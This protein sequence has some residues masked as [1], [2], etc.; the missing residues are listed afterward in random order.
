M[1]ANWIVILINIRAQRVLGPAQARRRTG[2]E[3]FAQEDFRSVRV[4]PVRCSW[5]PGAYPPRR[6]DAV[7]NRGQVQPT[8]INGIQDAVAPAFALLAGMQL[9]LFTPIAEDELTAEELAVRLDVNANRLSRL[10]YALAATGLVTEREGS[11]RDSPE[12]A[13]FLVRGRTRYMGGSHELLA[14]IWS[15][16]LRTAE[17]TRT[18]KPAAQH[19]WTQADTE[20]DAAALRGLAPLAL[21]FG[22]A[23]GERLDLSKVGSVVDIGGGSGTLLL[24]LMERWP[25]LRGTLLELPDVILHAEPI[26]AANGGA[27]RITLEPGNILERP[28]AEKHDLAVLRAVLQVMGREAAASA[29]RHTAQSL[30]PGGEVLISGG[31]ILNND[32]LGPLNA[33]FMNIT[34]M[35]LYR[36]SEAYT[37]EEHRTWL[38]AAG[39][40]QVTREQLP[41]GKELIR[42]RLP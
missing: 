21:A 39:F 11:F 18:G 19:D 12:A 30:N 10:L 32:R 27:D 4:S 8:T 24:G 31:G 7:P 17:S 37:E 15:A 13:E 25:R 20:S 35:N 22:R 42:G 9:D 28:A 14:S 5:Y 29:I 3:R 33:V 26:L 34:F 41:D 6:D 1:P 36:E 38:S 16:N 40:I 2:L 23:V